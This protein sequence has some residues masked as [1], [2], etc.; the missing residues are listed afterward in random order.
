VIVAVDTAS[1]SKWFRYTGTGVYSFHLLSECLRI[2]G[3]GELNFEFHGFVA[4]NDNWANSAFASPFLKVHETALMAHRRLWL[5]GGMA[6]HTARVRP[7]VVFIPTAHH[8]LPGRSAPTVTTIHDAIPRRLPE[9]MGEY[10]M[11]FHAM[12]WINAKLAHSIITVSAC[13]KKDLVE[14][15][16]IKPEKIEVVYNGCDS[17]LFNRFPPDREASAALLARMGI[18]RPYVLHHG[19]LDFR[20]NIYRLIQAWDRVRSACKESD[21]QLVLAGPMGLGHERILKVREA[22]PN[23]DRI[24]LTGAL[25]DAELATLV[26]N[27]SLCVIPSLYE[28]FCLPMVEAMACGVPTVASSSSCI[29]EVS[30]GILE[31]FDPLSVEQMAEVIRRALED[32]DLRDRLREKGL[33]RAAEFSWQ[34][35]AQETLRIFAKTHMECSPVNRARPKSS[36]RTAI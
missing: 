11:P 3:A 13:S 5:L 18:R 20:K 35:C 27:A 6:I 23:R 1:L 30:G 21:V 24:I 33:A 19:M 25:P 2:A 34:R 7:D 28:G 29:P 12:T 14:I 26:K 8:S 17:D 10:S 31:Y 32:S 15:Y 22:S 9:S 16:G 4:P 36:P